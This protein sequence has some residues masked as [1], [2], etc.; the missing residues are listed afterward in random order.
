MLN[1]TGSGSSSSRREFSA[2]MAATLLVCAL[3][4]CA[5]GVSPAFAADTALPVPTSLP[6]AATLAI[7]KGEPLVLLVSLPGCPYCEMVRRSYLLPMRLEGLP[8]WQINTTDATSPLEGF[9]GQRSSGAEFTRER[10]IR[11]TPTVLFLDASG[12]EL[13][14]PLE[15]FTG[16][17][18]YGAYLNEALANARKTVKS[19]K[20]LN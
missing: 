9:N 18:F 19:L 12:R 13:A 6:R 16:P 1:V 15:G 11:I 3:V 14:P 10:G 5:L 17:D 2:V 20:T 7:G 8:A 4:V